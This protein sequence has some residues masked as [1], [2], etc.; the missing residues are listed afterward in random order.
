MLSGVLPSTICKT[1]MVKRRQAKREKWSK[2]KCSMTQ[3]GL[4]IMIA[5]A[6]TVLP[7]GKSPADDETFSQTNLTYIYNPQTPSFKSRPVC[8]TYSQH[9]CVI[10]LF[11]YHTLAFLSL[12]Y[13]CVSAPFYVLLNYIAPCE[14]CPP[15]HVFY[16]FIHH[17][18][19]LSINLLCT[20][21]LST[22]HT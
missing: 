4:G 14:K 22:S 3:R 8:K 7:Q 1:K 6:V 16:H 18:F 12:L 19:S 9:P 2:R 10:L 13:F 15:P 17:L 11:F 20:H 21:L 5:S